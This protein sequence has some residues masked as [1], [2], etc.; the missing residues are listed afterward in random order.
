MTQATQE[1]ASQDKSA[2]LQEEKPPMAHDF[3]HQTRADT[4]PNDLLRDVFSNLALRID[5][6]AEIIT[7]QNEAVCT[8]MRDFSTLNKRVIELSRVVDACFAQQEEKIAHQSEKIFYELSIIKD[9][10]AQNNSR[11]NAAILAALEDMEQRLHNPNEAIS[12]LESSH[13]MLREILANRDDA[14][15]V[16]K[17]SFSE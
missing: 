10:I 2:P 7:T 8:L 15:H 14:A 13:V 9:E 5:Q 1:S 17:K 12:R 16:N 6:I 3:I 4:A 11:D